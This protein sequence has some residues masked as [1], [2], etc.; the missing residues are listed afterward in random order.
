MIL[1]LREMQNTLQAAWFVMMTAAASAAELMPVAQ[2]NA[3]VQ[4]YCAVC[5]TDA[6]KNGG[7]SLEHFDAA[8]AA[9]SLTAM[10][11]SKL[12]GGVSLELVKAVG[13]DA[14]AAALVDRKMKSGAMGAAGIP[15]PD[16]ATVDSLI[17]SLAVA[18]AGADEWTVERT[19]VLLTA[20]TLREAS[21]GKNAGEVEAYRLI[22]TCNAETRD[23]SMQLAWSPVPQS[24]ALS[25]S[26]DGAPAV[27]Y[28]VEGSERMG[29][30]G[31]AVVHGLAALMLAET[32]GGAHHARLPFPSES[33]TIRDLFPAETVTFSFTNL[34]ADTRREL[35]ACFS[36]R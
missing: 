35:A 36:E 20:S 3:L 10:L 33:L 11:L 21:S 1:T 31:K 18:S 17:H 25:A 26:A 19:G 9:P 29:N 8:Q 13:T 24:G 12:S 23:G 30:G 34:A 27:A 7:L 32:K 15:I 5:H 16:K 22:V 28:R 14:S 4:K 2:Q 6:A